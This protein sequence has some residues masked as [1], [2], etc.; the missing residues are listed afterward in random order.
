MAKKPFW[1]PF[2]TTKGASYHVLMRAF[3]G[4][5]IRLH[6]FTEPDT[7]H[8]HT[9]PANFSV[10]VIL[11][12]G[13]LEQTPNNGNLWWFQGHFGIVRHDT[14]HRIAILFRGRPCYTLWIR[15]RKVHDVI[16]T[17]APRVL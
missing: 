12:G 1:T 13:Y 17:D 15:S 2:P 3:G 4:W 6:K 5:V 9:H 14:A 10:R 11:K 16:V 7:H 8:F